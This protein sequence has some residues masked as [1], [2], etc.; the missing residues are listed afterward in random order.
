MDFDIQLEESMLNYM[1]F[2]NDMG[3]NNLIGTN[4]NFLSHYD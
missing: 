3:K 2:E 1:E 4:D